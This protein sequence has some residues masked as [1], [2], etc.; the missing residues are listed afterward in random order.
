MKKPM[1]L[2]ELI[3]KKLKKDEKLNAEEVYELPSGGCV[4]LQ[5]PTDDIISSTLDRLSDSSV[6]GVAD[7]YDF[8]IYN[9]VKEFKD[10]ALHE[11]AGIS[12]PTD[13]VRAILDLNDRLTLGTHLIEKAGL[14]DMADEVKKP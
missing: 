7:A 12:V 14:K 2:D 5:T 10:P 6:S 9:C 1:T 3:A 8:L 13:T 11:Q 4:T